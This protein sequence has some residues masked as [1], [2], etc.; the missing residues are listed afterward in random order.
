MTAVTKLT[1]SDGISYR[2]NE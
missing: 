2:L 1:N